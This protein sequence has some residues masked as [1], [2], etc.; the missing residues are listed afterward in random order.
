VITATHKKPRPLP[1]SLPGVTVSFEVDE[2]SVLE[3][4]LGRIQ[5]LWGAVTD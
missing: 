5:V 1:L 2:T 4:R 3:M